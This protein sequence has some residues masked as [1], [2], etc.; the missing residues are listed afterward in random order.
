MKAC[1][2]LATLAALMALLL[3]AAGQTAGQPISIELKDATVQ[4]ALSTLFGKA[5]V[6]YVVKDGVS[7][8]VHDLSMVDV[9]FEVALKG[10]L[11]QCDLTYT[12]ENGVYTIKPKEGSA[13]AMPEPAVAP[14]EVEQPAAARISRKS[15]AEEPAAPPTKLR[16]RLQKG[17]GVIAGGGPSV[18]VPMMGSGGIGLLPAMGLN[19]PSMMAGIRGPMSRPSGPTIAPSSMRTLPSALIPPPTLGGLCPPARPST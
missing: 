5:G 12:V 11:R 4:E 2:G 7:G 14:A 18:G 19:M 3:G 10:I 16:L 9:P 15:Y 6:T 1:A 8:T 17:T 13:V